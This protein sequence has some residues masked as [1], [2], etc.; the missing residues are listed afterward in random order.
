M[1]EGKENMEDQYR[2]RRHPR[3]EGQRGEQRDKCE[4]VGVRLPTCCPRDESLTV[5]CLSGTERPFRLG[6]LS[7]S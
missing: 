1:M 6:L 5:S 2:Y 4:K 7:L 3:L